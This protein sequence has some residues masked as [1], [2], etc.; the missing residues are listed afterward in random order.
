MV[1]GEA[2]RPRVYIKAAYKTLY[3]RLGA[4][5]I[6]GALCVG[7]VLVYNYPQLVAVLTSGEKSAAALP[8]VI[9]MR[10]LRITGL[11]HLVNTILVTSIFS[12][13]NTLIYCATR[14]LYPLAIEG[15]APKILRECTKVGDR[16]LV[17]DAYARPILTSSSADQLFHCRDGFSVPVLSSIIGQL[18][19][20][21]H[22]ADEH[23]RNR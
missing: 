1:A 5:F 6:L 7:I 13:G 11:P 8:Y 14:S 20:G 22:L 18:R 4:F 23:H 2:K 17:L 9:A 15:R 19:Q 10:N 3:Y 16:Y 12:A 21:T